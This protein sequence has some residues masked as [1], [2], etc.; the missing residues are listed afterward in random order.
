MKL[1]TILIL[2]ALGTLFSFSYVPRS[3][4]IF[5][6]SSLGPYENY[7]RYALIAL[8]QINFIILTINALKNKKSNETPK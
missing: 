5:Q 6:N 7:L 2:W 8:I 3:G 1:R 4:G